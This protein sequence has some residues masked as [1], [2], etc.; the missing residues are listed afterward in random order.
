M[1]TMQT[2]KQDMNYKYLG[3]CNNTTYLTIKMNSIPN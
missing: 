3:L 1:Q 2:I